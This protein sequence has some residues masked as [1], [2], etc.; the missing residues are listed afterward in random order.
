[1]IVAVELHGALRRV[2]TDVDG[3][4][5]R[6]DVGYG[7]SVA[8]VVAAAGLRAEEV[9]RIARGG[10]FVDLAQAVRDG[11]RLVV[12]PPLGGG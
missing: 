6:V 8:D 11:D 2:A 5:A 10:D 4:S 1:M 12:F 9:W 3:R 7:A